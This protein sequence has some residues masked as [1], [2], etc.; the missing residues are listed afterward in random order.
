MY[1]QLTENEYL[2][3]K[4]QKNQKNNNENKL[5]FEIMNPEKKIEEDF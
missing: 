3:H 1:N 5:Q 2:F 4:K